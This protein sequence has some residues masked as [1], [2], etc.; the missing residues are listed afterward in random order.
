MKGE[1]VMILTYS[2]VIKK[3]NCVNEGNFPI[4]SNTY[5]LRV[6]D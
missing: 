2:C 5:K 4:A 6:I 1:K 3:C